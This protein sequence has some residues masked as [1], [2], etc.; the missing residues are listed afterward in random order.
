MR[1]HSLRHVGAYGGM[2]WLFWNWK[3]SLR[4]SGAAVMP[5]PEPWK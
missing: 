1:P 5:S 4:S 3:F 2:G